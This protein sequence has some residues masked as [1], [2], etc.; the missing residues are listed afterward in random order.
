MK[1]NEEKSPPSSKGKSTN[2][3]FIVSRFLKQKEKKKKKKKRGGRKIGRDTT[4][5]IF[6]ETSFYHRYHHEDENKPFF[7]VHAICYKL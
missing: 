5:K 2:L 6:S 1:P 3:N 4:D 7:M